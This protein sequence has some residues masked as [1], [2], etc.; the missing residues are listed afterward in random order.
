VSADAQVTKMLFFNTPLWPVGRPERLGFILYL[1]AGF[2]DGIIVPFFPLWARGEG[3]IAVGFIGLLFGCYAGGE[4]FATPFIGG[5]AD[6]IGRR[7]VL[8]ASSMGVG[9]G[10]IGL[11]FAHGVIEAAVVFLGIGI[12]ESVVH[13]TISTIIADSTPADDHRRQFSLAR[14]SSSIGGVLGPAAGAVLAW[15]YLGNVF[16]AAGIALLMGGILMLV[17]LPETRS[18]DAAADEDDEEESFS[19]LLPAFRDRRLATLLLWFMLLEIA[20]SWIEAVLPLYAQDAAALTPSGVGFLF[21][22]GAALIAIVQI[23][24]TRM[25][26]RQSALFLVLGAGSALILAFGILI[27]SPTLA[28]LIAAV[29][30]FSLSQMLTG[31]LVPTAVN[32]LAPSNHRATYMAAAS[33]AS[34]LRDS[35]GPATGTALYAASSQLPWT[36]GIPFAAIAAVGL[37]TTIARQHRPPR[38][39]SGGTTTKPAPSAAERVE[40]VSSAIE[41]SCRTPSAAMRRSSALPSLR[42]WCTLIDK[43]S[44]RLAKIPGVGPRRGSFDDEN[45]RSRAATLAVDPAGESRR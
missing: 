36:I 42:G 14:V 43:C 2:A 15:Q 19:A 40:Q 35:V 37:G 7:P 24:V 38:P 6:R 27:A 25:A 16:I 17:C 9:L 12:C 23:P 29:S 18:V 33:V 1:C 30:L 3:D 34:D 41:R 5:I 4:L 10:F 21:T 8:I 31:P 44:R 32:Q 20:G 28:A 39:P 11:Y 13:P 45:S 22:Y 26:G